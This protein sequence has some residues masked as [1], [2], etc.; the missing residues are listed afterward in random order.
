M[1]L[2]HMNPE[3]CRYSDAGTC[4]T[5]QTGPCVGTG[6]CIEQAGRQFESYSSYSDD[7]QATRIPLGVR[8]SYFDPAFRSEK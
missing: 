5:P 4:A 3:G 2:L 1:P 7:Q 8:Y 6:P